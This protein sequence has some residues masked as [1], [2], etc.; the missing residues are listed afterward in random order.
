MRYDFT[1]H[2]YYAIC[3]QINL[4]EPTHNPRYAALGV[5]QCPQCS[6]AEPA[7]TG[8]Y[9]DAWRMRH[10]LFLN[11]ARY[12]LAPSKDA[13]LRMHE[14]FP[15]APVRYVTHHDIPDAALL[16]VPRASRWRPMPI[17]ASLSSAA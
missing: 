12:V 1:A 7:P 10:R 9:I 15:D 6:G 16:P 14:Y 3:P 2:D 5:P 11:Q 13:A 17:C 4:M 8:E